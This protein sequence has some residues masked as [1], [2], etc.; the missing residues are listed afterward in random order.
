MTYGDGKSSSQIVAEIRNGGN[1]V[2]E[3]WIVPG[4]NSCITSAKN[5]TGQAIQGLGSS[6]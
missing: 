6:L 3:K 4:V 1:A 5:A 2:L